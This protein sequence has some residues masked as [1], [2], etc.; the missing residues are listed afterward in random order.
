[1]AVAKQFLDALYAPYSGL[2]DGFD[3]PSLEI[4]ALPPRGAAEGM[5]PVR[6]WFGLDRTEQAAEVCM[7][8]AETMDVYVGVLPRRGHGGKMGSVPWGGW[9]FAD[10]DGGDDG[11]A[12]AVQLVAREPRKWA[13][14]HMM[15][16]SGGGVHCYWR[17][18]AAAE[19]ADAEQRAAWKSAE[20][21]L[22]A[23]IGGA[24]PQAHA[25]P[26]ATDI[27]RILRVPGT[28][29]HKRQRP[30][31]LIRLRDGAHGLDSWVASCGAERR[32][33]EHG[34]ARTGTDHV[35]QS[36]GPLRRGLPRA[37]EWRPGEPI[38]DGLLRWART[39]Y[40]EGERHGRIVSDAKWLVRD[41]G[42]PTHVAETLIRTKA[43]ASPG[44]HP[45][46]DG[47]LTAMMRWANA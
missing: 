9:L 33:D 26:Q 31:E 39:G 28:V 17:L 21:G 47:E 38:P 22:V 6:Q 24:A 2:G 27:A 32:T 3:R 1:M 12:G 43:M 7:G 18:R 44:S 29:N 15:V 19:L 16:V 14:P 40:V 13:A 11:V 46:S 42:M 37:G 5:Q 10:I 25:D 45:I 30:V 34:P 41:I 8:L 23:A 36:I 35:P 20:K 4:R